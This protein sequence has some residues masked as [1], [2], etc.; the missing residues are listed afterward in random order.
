MI[1]FIVGLILVAALLF[2]TAK[3]VPQNHAW[4]L[5]FLGKYMATWEAG[6]HF[7]IPVLT[8]IVKKVSLKEQVLDFPPQNVITKDNVGMKIDTVLY[9]QVRDPKLFAY[10]VEAPLMALE[11]LTATTLRNIIGEMELDATLTSRDIINSKMQSVIDEATDPW[12]IKVN[13]VEVKNIMPPASIQEAM[14]KQMKAERERREAILRAEGEKKSSILTAEGNKEAAILEAQADKESALLRAEAERQQQILLAQGQAEAIREVAEA[15]AKGLEIVKSVV[16]Q[17]G[18]IQIQALET[19]SKMSE[20]N[21][22]TILIPSELQGLGSMF[23]ALNSVNQAT[24]K[25]LEEAVG[26]LKE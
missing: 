2:A 13:R 19:L 17:E 11:N 1:P 12:G 21:A 25:K 10:G 24:E 18:V 8:R 16:G 15:R 6:L 4:V 3:V 9:M 26:Q 14:E 20:G 22:T 5:E 7:R 23:T